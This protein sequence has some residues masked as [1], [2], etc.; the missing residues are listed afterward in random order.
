MKPG[1][2]QKHDEQPSTF[3]TYEELFPE[4][5]SINK[6]QKIILQKMFQEE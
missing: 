6:E 5:E 4:T 3:L 2:K 1:R